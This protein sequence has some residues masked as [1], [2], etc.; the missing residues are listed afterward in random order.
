MGRVS[1]AGHIGHNLPP[2]FLIGRSHAA[3]LRLER[4]DISG[5]HAVIE[6]RGSCWQLRDLAST[7][8]TQLNGQRL[9]PGE[10]NPLALGDR[11][12]FGHG[13]E[14]WELEDDGEPEVFGHRMADGYEVS[15][16]AGLLA[17]PSDDNPV[18]QI[19][20]IGSD[21]W[22]CVMGTLEMMLEDRQH[23]E[24]EGQRWQVFLPLNC[25]ETRRVDA[26]ES[27]NVTHL[28]LCFR[29]SRDEEH[30]AIEIERP[31]AESPI[32]IEP[33]AHNYLLLHLA[34]LRLQDI[35]L[36]K[37]EQGWVS[38]SDVATDLRVDPTHLNVQIFR[39]R[40]SFAEVGV[41]DVGNLVETRGRPG[42]MRIGVD[43]LRVTSL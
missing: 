41:V 11:L 30:V 14:G 31:R 32:V 7:N 13:G 28:A 27:T 8:G 17:L 9:V 29:V 2:R 12:N 24:I 39:L 20:H 42:Q 36:P 4:D 40:R 19:M 6:W 23:I 43:N 10:P 18:A 5:E 3:H 16:R 22:C 15:G 21:Q 33:R 1:C 34:R 26:V 38:R 25:S 35:A 37:T